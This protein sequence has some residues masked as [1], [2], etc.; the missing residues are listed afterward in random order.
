MRAARS[1]ITSLACPSTRPR[2][3][4]VPART[5]CAAHTPMMVRTALEETAA[6]GAFVRAPS[7]LR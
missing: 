7:T 6:D 1:L 2:A 4:P 5:T 3:A